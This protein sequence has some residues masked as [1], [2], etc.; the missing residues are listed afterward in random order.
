[1]LPGLWP[2]DQG[3]DMS[4]KICFATQGELV[5]LAY[6]ALGVLSR[7]EASDADFDEKA[8][9]AM[10]KKL[11]KVAEEKGIY[12][13]HSVASARESSRLTRMKIGFSHYANQ[14]VC[15]S[16]PRV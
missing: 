3:F 6:D 10:Q 8:K 15:Y 7:K 12:L 9:K 14:A 5:K 13:D 11:G 2:G 4:T 1:M 16:L